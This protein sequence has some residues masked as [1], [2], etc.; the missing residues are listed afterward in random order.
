MTTSLVPRPSIAG[1]SLSNGSQN[2]LLACLPLAVRTRWAFHLDYVDLLQGQVL[3]ET[4]DRMPH[5]YFPVNA[6]V[7]QLY[8][9]ENGESA[10]SALIGCKGLV[11][12]PVV[13]GGEYTSTRAVVV[14]AGRAW[15]MKADFLRQE[16]I[17][18][19][20]DAHFKSSRTVRFLAMTRLLKS[21][22]GRMCSG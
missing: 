7:V 15:R 18:G 21:P 17:A 2:E 22:T 8:D 12:F 6:V 10:E 13:L 9:L 4:D 14:I 20:F 3:Q 16:V 1:V 19:Q 5:V 11:G